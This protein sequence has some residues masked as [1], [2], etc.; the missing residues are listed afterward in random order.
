[1]RWI[2]ELKRRNVFRVGAA[3]VLLGWVII[4][5]T[6]TVS[7]A[8]NLPPWT[9][10]LV[11]WLG[12]IGL[13]FALVL[14]WAF[15]LT[16]DG[17]RRD[18][19][20]AEATPANQ[21][22]AHRLNITL[23][24]LLVVTIALVAW[25]SF[26]GPEPGAPDEE[27][28]ASTVDDGAAPA[29]SMSIAVLPLINMS[30]DTENAFFA[31]GVHEEILTNLSR[32][33]GLR[34][35]SRT[36]ALRYVDSGRS[37]RDIGRELDVRYIVE[38]SVRRVDNHVRI[39]VQLIDA[40]SDGHLWASNYDRELVNVFAVQS[41]VANSITNSLHLEIQPETIGTLDDLPT[42]SV[43]AYDLYMKAAS[44][45][46][47]EPESEAHLLEQREYLEAAV[48][49][50]PGFV[51]AWAGL[52]EI[53]DH[54]ARNLLQNQWFGDSESERSANLEEI[55][56][57]ARRALEMAV[58]LDPDNVMSLLAQASDYVREQE[59]REFQHERKKFI[60]RALEIDPDNA[61]A[62]L[63]LGWWYRIEGDFQSATP[64]FKKALELDPLHTRIVDSSLVH[65]RFSGDQEMTTLLFERLAQLAPEKAENEKL[66]QIHPLAR[67]NNIA[68]LF[69]QT[70]DETL[71]DRYAET[72]DELAETVPNVTE[73]DPRLIELRMR[74]M[75]SRLLQMRGD[76]DA[77]LE[78]ER[79]KAP[80]DP[81]DLL[82]LAYLWSQ[83]GFIAVQR[84]RDGST[85]I[86][87][88]PE[89]RT[90]AHAML[91]AYATV[92]DPASD[93][94]SLAKYPMSIAYVTLG[95]D[96]RAGQLRRML[97]TLDDDTLFTNMSGPFLA[98]SVLDPDN[99]VQLALRQKAEHPS[100]F[101]TDW[102]A[103]L[104]VQTR[105]FLVHP[106][107]QA[108][109][110]EEGKWIDYLAARVPE[111]AKYRE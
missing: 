44:I 24:A 90:A 53:L 95:D 43:K 6:D 38:G 104:H 17:I 3:Y 32:I 61:V 13:P 7:P 60:D 41:E 27:Q 18:S 25:D 69:T 52:N 97:D 92:E 50:D 63:V 77:L 62:W 89:I 33:E 81:D 85:G 84:L 75:T 31:G 88:T 93:L 54:S 67:L 94:A 40:A 64:A 107:M 86:H 23:V 72:L 98:L 110:V 47:S 39:T 46:R 76:L 106:E 103:M 65:F 42:R 5:F 59:S 100:W 29:G 68:V 83:A 109:Y 82:T 4:Q 111:Y 37:L 21:T 22:V 35:V 45:D 108:F 11:I 91:D 12:I 70:A 34:V 14:A 58:S 74:D 49:E 55:R 15:E 71:I 57:S 1:M 102:A 16:P 30:A 48:A 26:S 79:P 20:H 8:L 10:S 28:R 66:G 36:T 2:E 73:M 51:E 56:Q 78:L 96:E 9:L 105:H 80:D 87:D 99:A 101:G 19:G